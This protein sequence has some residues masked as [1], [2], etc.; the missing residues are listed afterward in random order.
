MSGEPTSAMATWRAGDVSPRIFRAL[1]FPA[2]T[3]RLMSRTVVVTKSVNVH[4]SDLAVFSAR[5]CGICGSSFFSHK[6]GNVRR[7]RR[8][9]QIENRRPDRVPLP[10]TL[11]ARRA[12]GVSPRIFRAL[13][14]PAL[15][16][17][18]V[19]R[20]VVVTKPVNVHSSDL[21]VFSAQIC[22]ICGSSFF[23]N[24]ESSTD[25]TDVR[26][27]KTDAP[28]VFRSRRRYQRG[29]PGASVPG[30]SGRCADLWGVALRCS[31]PT[32]H[33]SNCCRDKISQR[34]QLRSRSL[35][36]ANL[37]KSAQICVICGICGSSF[38]SHKP[39]IVHRFHRCAQI[40]NRYPHRVPLPTTLPARRA[41]SRTVVVT[42]QSTS[43]AQISQS[44]LRESA[45][46]VDRRSSVT[47]QEMSTDFAD[48][49]RLKTDTP[50]VSRSRSRNQRGEPGCACL[51]A[52]SHLFATRRWSSVAGSD[53]VAFPA[54]V[55][56]S[57]RFEI[58]VLPC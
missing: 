7:F 44:S 11:P 5:I 58:E 16:L 1:R 33:E 55:R 25:F 52:D 53:I 49:R 42:N 35:L 23:T 10:T 29:E 48:V 46:S 31:H 4:S 36:C 28:T 37:R 9:A 39:G 57:F 56:F 54:K 47:N 51:L 19:S 30:S 21:A 45:E 40:E 2:R 3:L 50:T 18:L 34:P 12:G 8:F 24:Q 17:R 22:V 41:G 6:P 26:R 38:F 20:T 13:R 15:T 27:L 43:T 32:T 14:F